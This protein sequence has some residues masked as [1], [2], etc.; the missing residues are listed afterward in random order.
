MMNTIPLSLIVYIEQEV[1]PQYTFFDK[2]HQEDHVR[3]VINESLSLANHYEVNHAM[4]YTVAAC[5]DLG[6]KEGREHHHTASKRILLQDKRLSE[7][8]DDRQ[9]NIMA[10]AVEDHRASNGYEPRTIYGKIIAEADRLIDTNDILLRTI[11][12]GMSHYPELDKDGHY[13]RFCQHLNDKYARGG[14]LKLWIP[15]SD[16][17]RNLEELRKVIEDKDE[18]KRLFN[19]L[20]MKEISVK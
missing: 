2:A 11:Q 17:A 16:N 8:F 9:I 5:H 12:Y 19:E 15:Q 10:D 13:Q 4:V 1:I 14:Y 7:W 3:R 20:Y 6:L 18:L